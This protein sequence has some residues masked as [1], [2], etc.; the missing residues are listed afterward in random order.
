MCI[1]NILLVVSHPLIQHKLMP[2]GS[3][4]Y[5]LVIQLAFQFDYLNYAQIM[6]LA[7]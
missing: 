4:L 3:D 6:Y 1:I 7:L 2:V 5:L